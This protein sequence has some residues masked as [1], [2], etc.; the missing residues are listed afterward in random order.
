MKMKH[1]VTIQEAQQSDAEA[2]AWLSGELG[3]PATT[4]EIE[5]RLKALSADPRHTILVAKD[6]ALLGWIDVAV[7]HT[8]ESDSFAE[9]RGLVVTEARRGTGIGTKLVEAAEKWAS[10]KKCDRIRVRTNITR[11]E[12]QAFYQQRG[13]VSKKTQNVFD[14]SIPSNK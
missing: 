7:I 11:V 6:G 4:S 8:L 10:A 3:Y 5:H 13:Y 9:I 14:K 12:A 1:N 2:L